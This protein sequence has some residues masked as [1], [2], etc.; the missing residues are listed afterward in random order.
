M[1]RKMVGDRERN[2]LAENYLIY[3]QIGGPRR[4]SVLLSL[5]EKGIEYVTRTGQ[6]YVK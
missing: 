4:R 1:L 2:E 5:T 6:F 3:E